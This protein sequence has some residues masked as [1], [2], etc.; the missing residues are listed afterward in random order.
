MSK[1]VICAISFAKTNPFHVA[2]IR[3]DETRLDS[4]QE[5]S[6]RFCEMYSKWEFGMGKRLNELEISFGW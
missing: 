6:M 4:A 1:I 2:Q 5:S 3:A